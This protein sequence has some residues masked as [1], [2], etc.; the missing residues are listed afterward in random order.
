VAEELHNGS[1][2]GHIRDLTPDEGRRLF[3][4]AAQYYLGI[5]GDEFIRRW[6]SGYYD[7]DP[8]EVMGVAMLLPFATL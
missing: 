6:E 5:S 8:E 7:D 1:T 4:N 3:D 2:N